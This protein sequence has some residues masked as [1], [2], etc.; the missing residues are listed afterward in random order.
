MIR[1]FI[2]IDTYADKVN[3]DNLYYGHFFLL[4]VCTVSYW[5]GNN[6][7]PYCYDNVW[8][9]MVLENGHPSKDSIYSMVDLFTWDGWLYMY[10]VYLVH[11]A[12]QYTFRTAVV[13]FMFMVYYWQV[14][15]QP[16]CVKGEIDIF[17]WDLCDNEFMY[18]G[19]DENTI[20]KAQLDAFDD[21]ADII[22]QSDQ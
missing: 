5:A 20:K 13:F 1:N 8:A 11:Y 7:Y 17:G 2:M 19:I 15:D 4:V 22:E 9:D 18:G 14:Y 3:W 21:A 6:S 16:F 12:I 10:A